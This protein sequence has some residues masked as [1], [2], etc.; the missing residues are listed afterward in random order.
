M[1][2]DLEVR[3]HFER[4]GFSKERNVFF[5][6]EKEKECME[7][8]NDHFCLIDFKYVS[9]HPPFQIIKN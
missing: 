7:I 2:F 1:R 6:K 4:I 8:F 3:Q 5:A 9:L